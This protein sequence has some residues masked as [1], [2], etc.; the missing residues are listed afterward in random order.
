MLRCARAFLLAVL[1]ALSL[2]AQST[3]FVRL[4]L[5][6]M[7]GYATR[8]VEAR[9]L[10]S[11]S[12]WNAEHTRIFTYTTFEVLDSLKGVSPGERVVVKQFGGKVGH[13]VMHVHGEPRFQP[14]D[15]AVLFL[16][17]DSEEPGTAR[18]VGMAQG[19]FRVERDRATGEKFVV[20]ALEG[21]NYF[22]PRTQMFSKPTERL[23]L[24]EF[25]QRV[26]GLIAPESAEPQGEATRR[27]EK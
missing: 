19:N 6:E 21:A 27:K 23:P 10:E 3:T 9:A 18:V 20:S 26:Q 7:T 5:E 15:E 2:P 1:L 24:E 13:L 22:D 17:D 11:H 25:K 12:E 4:S 8:I 14:G 16:F